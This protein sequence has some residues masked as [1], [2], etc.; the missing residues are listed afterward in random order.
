MEVIKLQQSPRFPNIEA[1]RAKRG[2]S[3]KTLMQKINVKS[4]KT[5]NNW[6]LNGKIP[7]NKLEKMAD[8]FECS[9]DYLLSHN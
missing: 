4:R 3:I 1:E 2:W 8:L 6:C 7:Q 5:Y 9:V